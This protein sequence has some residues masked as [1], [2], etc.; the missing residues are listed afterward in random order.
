MIQWSTANLKLPFTKRS[1]L[2]NTFSASFL[3]KI[4]RV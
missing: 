3:T 2:G 1:H 4:R